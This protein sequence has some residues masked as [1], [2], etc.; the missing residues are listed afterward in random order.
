MLLDSGILSNMPW[1]IANYI[2]VCFR[3]DVPCLNE[4]FLQFSFVPALFLFPFLVVAYELPFS[5]PGL[6]VLLTT[7]IASSHCVVADGL[8][9]FGT[10]VSATNIVTGR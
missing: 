4:R 3:R 2:S 5:P 6:P 8:C 1:S 10:N 7:P 9:L